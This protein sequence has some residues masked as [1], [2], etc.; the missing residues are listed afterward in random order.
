MSAPA[1]VN[2]M[3]ASPRQGTDN[4]APA[5][6]R[7]LL[8]ND[9]FR[10]FAIAKTLQLSGQNALVYG[11]FI[12]YVTKQDSYIAGS[13]FVL[14]SVLP[15]VLLSLPGGIVADR[16]PNK[17][18]IIG[19]M[20]VRIAIVARFFGSGLSLES[21]IALTF[22]IFTAY[23]FF[24]PA[25]N[26]A[27]VTLT[28]PEDN[29]GA[30]A[31]LQALSLLAQVA[32]AGIIAPLAIDLLGT[33]GLFAI[34]T[35]L[36]VISGVLY[37]LSPRLTPQRA[38]DAYRLSWWSSLPA[39]YRAIR[40]DRLVMQVTVLRVLNDTAMLMV[41]VAAPKFITDALDS[42]P[43]NAIYIASPA[44]IGLAL[45][46]MVAAPLSRIV[47][48][49]ILTPLGYGF[50]V[51]VLCCLPFIEQIS[52]PMLDALSWWDQ[53]RSTAG[54]S[55]EIATTLLLL[56]FAGF[57]IS[58]VQVSSR[59]AVYAR[60]SPGLLGQVLAT[61]SALGSLA[62][63]VPTFLAGALLDVL[64]VEVFLT[65]LAAAAIAAAVF[66]YAGAGQLPQ[67]EQPPG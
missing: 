19:V 52:G 25:E 27:V 43:E 21:V 49:R 38:V 42:S 46:L 56:P 44:A 61:Q 36:F 24:T 40:S 10:R 64:P 31:W 45:G 16:L 63:V 29:P 20:V 57:G 23:Q 17:L 34:V 14:A 37:W 5:A 59:A 11:L 41:L 32:G 65:A 13:A 48:A 50:F 3:E 60:I 66:G 1:T 55:P 4:E 54:L 18:V 30:L 51:A 35:L 28:R 47:S 12:A 62:A 22:L 6:R 2:S 26:E 67:R 7:S 33:D 53:V 15:S 8:Q 58:V 39:G 9:R